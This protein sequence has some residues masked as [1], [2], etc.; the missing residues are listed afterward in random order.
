MI[1]IDSD[2]LRERAKIRE[3]QLPSPKNEIFKGL[4]FGLLRGTSQIHVRHC[5]Y[6]V[7]CIVK[8]F[9]AEL[10]PKH[11]LMHTARHLLLLSQWTRLLP[12]LG[13]HCGQIDVNKAC[14][15]LD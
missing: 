10:C 12:I 7:M 14:P 4:Q 5:Q 3:S 6:L 15:L 8:L 9:V 13:H 11:Q 1:L 2:E